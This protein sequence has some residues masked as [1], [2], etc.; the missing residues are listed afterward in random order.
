MRSSRPS[1]VLTAIVTSGVVGFSLSLE[2]APASSSNPSFPIRF[3]AP[4]LAA[5]RY[6]PRVRRGPR[7]TIGTGSRGCEGVLNTAMTPLIPDGHIG[8]TTAG[9]PTFAWYMP[10]ANEVEFALV[11]PGIPKPLLVQRLNITE[12]GIVQLSLPEDAPELQFDRE[13]RWSLTMICPNLNR[14]SARPFVQ[15]WISRTNVTPEL[16]QQLKA[17]QG[18]GSDALRQRAQVYA[19]AGIWYDALATISAA[20][21]QNPTDRTLFEE[22]SL[23][24]E[25]VGLTKLLEPEQQTRIIE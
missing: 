25:Q 12:P 9:R 16:A 7:R 20:Y 23:L 17:V 8:L 4:V 18:S 22:R 15:G 19:A 10:I 3:G 14:F 2:Y 1:Q 21:L 11:E 13:Y 6:T 5:P 24:L